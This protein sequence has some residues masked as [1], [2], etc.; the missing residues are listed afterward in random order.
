MSRDRP[1]WIGKTDN[2]PI[3]PRIRLRVFEDDGGICQ[4]G[5]GIKIQSFDDWE[6][7]HTIAII[8][9]GENRQSN[10][11][12]LLAKHHKVKTA[13]DV[14]E[15]SIVAR[16]RMKFL[17][18]APKKGRPMPGSKASGFKKCMNGEVIRR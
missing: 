13:A 15:K 10:L 16:K 11:R 14:R 2:T 17:G 12:T 6:T 18:I 5:C 8:N 4:C 9:G 3:P 1:E 7:D